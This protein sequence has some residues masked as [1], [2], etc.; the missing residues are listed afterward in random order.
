MSQTSL[1]L[2]S[3]LTSTR[4]RRAISGTEIQLRDSMWVDAENR[5]WKH[6]SFGGFVTTPK[7]M[8]YIC[9]ILDEMSKNYPLGTTYEA[10]W[11][12]T[13]S[14]NGFIRMNRPGDIAFAAGFT[15]Q[16]GERTLTDRLH[17]LE[18]LGFIEI[19]PSG[20]RDIGFVFIPNPHPLI[21]SLYEAKV[22]MSAPSKLREIA[23]NLQES[24]YNAFLARALEIDAKDVKAFLEERKKTALK[25]E[26]SAGTEVRP[27][28]RR[29]VRKLRP[30]PDKPQ[31]N[32]DVQP[33]AP[34]NVEKAT[35]RGKPIRR[36]SKQGT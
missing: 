33:N 6:K 20:N 8:P 35:Q 2:A 30:V 28:V 27:P 11:S 26:A 32:A 25:P 7:T 9:R 22:G 36:L 29:L 3:L 1:D 31:K 19:K 14:N 10:L 13:W 34:A 15:G 23:A 16:R 5:I 12:F 4:R 18:R 21:L 17:R 24:T